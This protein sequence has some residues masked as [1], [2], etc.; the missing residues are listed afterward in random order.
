M[1]SECSDS[2]YDQLQSDNEIEHTFL[3]IKSKSKV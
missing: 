3:F 1:V 2:K